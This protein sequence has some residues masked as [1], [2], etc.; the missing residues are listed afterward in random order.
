M[1]LAVRIQCTTAGELRLDVAGYVKRGYLTAWCGRSAP[2]ATALAHA[3]NGLRAF[4]ADDQRVTR[5]EGDQDDALLDGRRHLDAAARE[6]RGGL[7]VARGSGQF[8]IEPGPLR[9]PASAGADCAYRW[10]EIPVLGAEQRQADGFLRDWESI[11]GHLWRGLGQEIWNREW[12]TSGGGPSRPA[13]VRAARALV[14]PEPARERPPLALST[15]L[16]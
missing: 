14:R 8:R 16:E 11:S 6:Q 9:S 12:M 1:S 15:V 13:L 5:A 3:S 10:R 2:P 4:G 7:E